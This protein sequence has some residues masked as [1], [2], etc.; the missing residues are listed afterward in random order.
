[1]TKLT[2]LCIQL[3]A[4]IAPFVSTIWSRLNP[5]QPNERRI[6]TVAVSPTETATE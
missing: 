2:Q 1:M 3:K 6:A 5:P 4:H